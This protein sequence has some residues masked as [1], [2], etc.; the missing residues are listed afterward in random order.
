VARHPAQLYDALIA[1]CLFAA[2]ALAPARLPAGTRFATALVVYG[3]ARLALGGVRL[4]PAFAFG[5]QI[6]QWLAAGAVASG[7]AL[8]VLPL[9]GHLR[10]A[11]RTRTAGT[12]AATARAARQEDSVAA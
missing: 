2:L 4:D 8:I 10:S 6:E 7:S 9:L 3:A 5:L 12:A 1:V 11:W